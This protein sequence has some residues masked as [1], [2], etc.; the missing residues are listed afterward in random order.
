MIIPGKKTDKKPFVGKIK[1]KTSAK[2]LTYG[3]GEG[4]DILASDI[5]VSENEL[6][7]QNI[8]DKLAKLILKNRFGKIS[9]NPGY[10]GVYGE[11]MLKEKQEKLI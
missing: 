4:A 10:D 1:N 8:D 2:I 6:I 7:N 11:A 9:V 3:F 5:N